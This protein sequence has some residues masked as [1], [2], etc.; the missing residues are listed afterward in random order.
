MNKRENRRECMA[1]AGGQYGLFT[2]VDDGA[3]GILHAKAFL[4]APMIFMGC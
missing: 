2:A 4:D 1:V 3:I